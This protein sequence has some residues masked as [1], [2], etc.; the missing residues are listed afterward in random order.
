MLK[1]LNCS[2]IKGKLN[3]Q[4]T[5]PGYTQVTYLESRSRDMSSDQEW[6]RKKNTSYF[7]YKGNP[8]Q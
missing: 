2:P 6:A 8:K 7:N 5:S 4:I 3:K 1:A